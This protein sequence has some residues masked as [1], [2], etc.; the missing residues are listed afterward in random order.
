MSTVDPSVEVFGVGSLSG[1]LVNN[2]L[3]SRIAAHVRDTK[4]TLSAFKR[5][6]T[7]NLIF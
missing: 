4:N 5:Q 1:P 6:L 7:N 2:T 3:A